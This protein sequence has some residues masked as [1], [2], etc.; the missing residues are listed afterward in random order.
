MSLKRIKLLLL[1]GV[2]FSNIFCGILLLNFFNSVIRRSDEQLK[3]TNGSIIYS[4]QH[5]SNPLDKNIYDFQNLYHLLAENEEIRY[6]EL[7]LQ[8]LENTC[9]DSE[10]F[11][12]LTGEIEP[13][14]KA[15]CCIQISANVIERCGLQVK[16]GRLFSEQDFFLEG[17]EPIPILMGASYERIYNIGDVFNFKYLYD[18]YRFE[19]IGFLDNDSKADIYDGELDLDKYII[20]P[21]FHMESLSAASNGLKI[22]YAN[23]ISGLVEIPDQ[24]MNIF[25]SSI[26]PLLSNAK[27]GRFSWNIYPEKYNFYDYFGVELENISIFLSGFIAANVLLCLWGILKSTTVFWVNG[28]KQFLKNTILISLISFV[29]YCFYNAIFICLLGYLSIRYIHLPIIILCCAVIMGI[30]LGG[31]KYQKMGER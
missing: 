30:S 20:M 8:Y 27:V 23:K 22:H 12:E 9:H 19:L 17:Q 4:I 28:T 3:K 10:F 18:D 1:I 31:A 24:D 15:V 21:S 29:F 25:Y 7:Y 16:E 11:S 13:F 2:C 6:Y 26:L 5:E 14:C